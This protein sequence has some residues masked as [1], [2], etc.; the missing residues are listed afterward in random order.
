MLCCPQHKDWNYFQAEE[1][2]LQEKGIKHEFEFKYF[3]KKI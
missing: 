3:S 2:K 1:T